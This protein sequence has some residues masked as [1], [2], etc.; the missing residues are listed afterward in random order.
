MPWAKPLTVAWPLPC[1][2]SMT[3]T[4]LPAVTI[5]R[6]IADINM[7]AAAAG[8][9]GGHPASARTVRAAAAT[10]DGVGAAVGD[11]QVLPLA[12][13]S[14]MAAAQVYGRLRPSPGNNRLVRAAALNALKSRK[15]W[16]GAGVEEC[17]CPLGLMVSN[18]SPPTR[19]SP[20]FSVA[21]GR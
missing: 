4:P 8:D 1:P 7:A 10:R 6:A 17:R 20:L 19:L 21:A 16:P 5:D 18:P 3:S 12:A 9:N 15:S 13:V 14:V 2:M 11:H